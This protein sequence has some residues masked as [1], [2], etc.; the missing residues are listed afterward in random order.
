MTASEKVLLDRFPIAVVI[1]SVDRSLDLSAVIKG[2][3]CPNRGVI[4]T[5]QCSPLLRRLNSPD[6]INMTLNHLFNRRQ[7]H[8]EV[9]LNP[10]T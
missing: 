1:H 3:V 4:R 9:S 6:L 5:E 2:W 7:L 8:L 10:L